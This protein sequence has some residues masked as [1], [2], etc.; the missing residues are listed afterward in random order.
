MDD[1]T[2]HAATAI[3]DLRLE[4]PKYANVRRRLERALIMA[5]PGEVIALCGPSRVGKTRCIHDVKTKFVGNR[6]PSDDRMPFVYVE[7]AN[8]AHGALLRTKDFTADCLRAI[9]HPFYDADE[10]GT[11]TPEAFD[12]F[13]HRT[14]EAT[15]KNAFERSLRAR[16]TQALACDEAHHIKYMQGGARAAARVL[17]SWKCLASKGQIKLIL[18]GSFELLDYIQLSPHLLGR[19]ELISFDRYRQDDADDVWAWEQILLTVDRCLRFASRKG[20]LREWND[21]LYNGSLG[22]LGLLLKWIRRALG[23]LDPGRDQFITRECLLA[24]AFSKV[25]VAEIADEIRRGETAMQSWLS[26]PA[27]KEKTHTLSVRKPARKPFRRALKRIPLGG[28]A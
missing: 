17:D 24:T 12:S 18:A 11:M 2:L 15:L 28:R 9:R 25:E 14:P 4:H 16:S 22:C 10:L 6:M 27:Q 26:S 20:T 7:V 1:W 19:L 8:E 21:L 5:N 23:S 3:N 13:I